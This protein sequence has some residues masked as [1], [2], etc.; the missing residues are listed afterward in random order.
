MPGAGLFA[1]LLLGNVSVTVGALHAQLPDGVSLQTREL[2]EGDPVWGRG[3]VTIVE[4]TDSRGVSYRLVR[5]TPRARPRWPRRRAELLRRWRAGHACTAALVDAFP[6]L[7]RSAR[8]PPQ[9]TFAGSCEGGDRYLARLLSLDRLIY[10][11]HV[12]QALRA[13][14]PEVPE[15]D[16][17]EAFARLVR[18]TRLD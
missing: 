5:V 4:G 11:L 17:R 13:N 3:H 15:S 14:A 18:G 16:L 2:E 8:T 9:I 6:P 12:D 1:L 7:R 10:E